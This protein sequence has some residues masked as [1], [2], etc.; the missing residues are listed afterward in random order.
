MN[1]AKGTLHEVGIFLG[2]VIGMMWGALALEQAARQHDV[3]AALRLTSPRVAIVE[4]VLLSLGYFS[5]LWFLR[6]AGEVSRLRR[7][8]LH[9]TAA[10]LAVLLL[11]FVSVV[12]QGMR[13]GGIIAV[14]VAVGIIVGLAASGPVIS[15]TRSR[16]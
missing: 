3:L 14:S 16:V 11:G 2:T 6:P 9:V 10:L 1:E 13:F 4:P 12:S 5:V 15:S 8:V 7:G